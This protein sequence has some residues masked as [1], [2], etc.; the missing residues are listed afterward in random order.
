[1]QKYNGLLS[2]CTAVLLPEAST[3][4][5]NTTANALHSAPLPKKTLFTTYKPCQP[6][7]T[8]VA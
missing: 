6:K 1:V 2:F 7:P 3:C 4:C 5:L 8:M